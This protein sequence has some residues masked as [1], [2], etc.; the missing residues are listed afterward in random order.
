MRDAA[1]NPPIHPKQVLLRARGGASYR[2]GR[3]LMRASQVRLK[4]VRGR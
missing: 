4:R 3:P 2:R 1:M